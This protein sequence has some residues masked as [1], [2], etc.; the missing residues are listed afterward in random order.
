MKKA[1]FCILLLHACI[2]A[3]AQGG[4]AWEDIVRETDIFDDDQEDQESMWAI[5]GELADHKI[6]L[7]T[8]TREDLLQIPFLSEEQVEEICEYLYRYGPM[9][10]MGE[11]AMIE[12]LS[13]E[14]RKLLSFFVEIK[15]TQD[16]G[17][18]L[19]G[20]ILRYGKH[21]LMGNLRVPLYKRKGDH[22]GYL[23]APYKH[24]FRYSFQ[25]GDYVKAGLIGAQDAG[26]PFFS[27]RNQYGYDYY[28]FYLH[29]R[30]WGRLKSLA[31]GRYRLNIGMGLVMNNDFALGKAASLMSLGR[32]AR[33][34]RPHSSRTDGNYLQGVAATIQ[35][36]PHI[37]ATAFVSH[38]Y[39]DAT[40][41]ADSTAISSIVT[42]GYHRTVAEMNKKHCA[43]ETL[44]GSH[45]HF[46]N[47]RL[48]WGITGVKN[49]VSKEILPNTSQQYRQYYPS[50]KHF[51]NISTDYGISIP[52]LSFHGETATGDCHALATI[53]TL[54]WQA[55]G[56]VTLTALQRFYSYKY[57]SLHSQG[58][59]EGGAIQNESG[60]YLGIHWQPV[61]QLLLKC[62]SDYAYFAWQK[63][64]AGNASH[65][66][67]NY[68]AATY[69]HGTSTLSARYRLR[70]RERDNA[71]KT[72]LTY[73]NEHR[74]RLSFQRDTQHWSL[75]TQADMSLTVHTHK[76]IGW[77][78]SQ[79]I[80][81]H[82]RHTAVSGFLAYFHTD[83]Y[84][85]RIYGYEKQPLYTFSFPMYY[86]EGIRY[87][88][89]FRQDI[90]PHWMV[91]V[92]IGTTN[93][94]DRNEI[95]TGLQTIPYSSQTDIDVQFRWK[96]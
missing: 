36:T 45:I 72:A 34:I 14:Q 43:T 3:C 21:E 6:H 90:H 1:V 15:D 66:W 32:S 62:Y 93:Y 67:D 9:K 41:H 81:F 29:V 77:M 85:S 79:S 10:S 74:G 70:M 78:V 17:F 87:S 92:K 91:I 5:L 57:Y 44:A 31:L 49:D 82:Y 20:R 16:K 42:S 89:Y 8:A 58:F 38:H 51:W 33:L 50:G 84:D 94:F 13:F 23:G 80:G 30:K 63:Y 65:A 18:P 83:D 54:S 7:N 69:Q 60:I 2:C 28:S 19:I 73:K 71:D 37:D 75:K 39:I 55:S 64:Q 61:R 47:K 24:S 52:H 86:G 35:L 59:S 48:H 68:I 4:N 56:N 26:E 25:Y 12:S 11:L 46:S 53:N 40:L 96:F 88:L 22:D 27:N 76:S 95:G